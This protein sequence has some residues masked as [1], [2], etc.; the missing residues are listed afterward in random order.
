MS[1]CTK[2]A[3]CLDKPLLSCA[4]LCQACQ[5]LLCPKYTSTG[6]KACC[7]CSLVRDRVVMQG[8]KCLLLSQRDW[9]FHNAFALCDCLEYSRL[10]S[11][12][13]FSQ[14]GPERV[15]L[16][17]SHD[18]PG[19]PIVLCVFGPG[20]QE[21]MQSNRQDEIEVG[22]KCQS[23]ILRAAAINY[24]RL[25]ASSNDN[26]GPRALKDLLAHLS[27]MHPCPLRRV[28]CVVVGSQPQQVIS[29]EQQ[30]SCSPSLCC[31]S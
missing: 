7:A 29:K 10:G 20:T 27:T 12:C 9:V 3:V 21:T 13:A 2:K 26:S 31:K 24:H 4:F 5:S 6:K 15:Q 8:S 18:F 16:N 23:I 1:S 17:D 22:R 25:E 30:S 14:Q 28:R 19:K 11:R